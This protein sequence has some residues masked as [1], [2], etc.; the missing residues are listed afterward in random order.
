M[1]LRRI[2]AATS[3]HLGRIFAAFSQHFRR[4][5]AAFSPHFRSTEIYTRTR[6]KHGKT[7]NVF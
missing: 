7:A 4:I 1:H 5:F 6:P 3:P 2:F